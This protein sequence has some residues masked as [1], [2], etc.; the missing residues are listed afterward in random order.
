[1]KI[2]WFPWIQI[3]SEVLLDLC[4]ISVF[5]TKSNFNLFFRILFF[6]IDAFIIRLIFKLA[7]VHLIA[8][9]ILILHVL[10][11]MSIVIGIHL[12][13]VTIVIL[14][15]HEIHITL[16]PTDKFL[17]SWYHHLSIYRKGPFSEPLFC[18]F[19]EKIALVQRVGTK[20]ETREGF[21]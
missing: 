20:L 5:Q 8:F 21:G 10:Y 9:L 19:N 15:L 13:I 17:I 14:I 7:T 12:I 16:L 11:P 2:R 18:F 1:M 3:F 6:I 4:S